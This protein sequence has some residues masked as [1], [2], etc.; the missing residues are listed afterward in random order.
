VLSEFPT[1]P[2][3]FCLEFVDLVSFTDKHRAEIGRYFKLSTIDLH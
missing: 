1:L 3:R 2:A